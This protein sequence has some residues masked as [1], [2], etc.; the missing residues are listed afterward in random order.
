MVPSVALKRPL[1]GVEGVAVAEPRPLPPFSEVPFLC[2]ADPAAP[3]LWSHCVKVTLASCASASARR[4]LCVQSC[5]SMACFD[6]SGQL[7]SPMRQEHVGS[8]GW[9]CL[10]FN[11][12]P[13]TFEI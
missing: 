5:S 7:E 8:P 2:L 9:F 4:P 11:S 12:E 3:E 10:C 6:A 13:Q 1:G